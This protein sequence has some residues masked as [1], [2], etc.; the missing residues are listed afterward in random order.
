MITKLAPILIVLALSAAGVF[1]DFL[2][3]LA[4]ENTKPFLTKWFVLGAV[5]YA[6]TAFGW[7][8]AFKHLKVGTLGAFYALFTVL[9]LVALGVFYFNEK[10]NHYELTGIVLAIISIILLSRFS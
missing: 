3:K 7:T 8:V 6:I 10:L 9:L 5:V 2:I 4:S 1:G